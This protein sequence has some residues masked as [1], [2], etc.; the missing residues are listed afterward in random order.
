MYNHTMSWTDRLDEDNA[1]K[2][3]DVLYEAEKTKKI[4]HSI[5]SAIKDLPYDAEDELRN[6]AQKT[7]NGD[8][9]PRNPSPYKR[10]SLT[11]KTRALNKLY[12]GRLWYWGI[13]TLEY[14]KLWNDN[15]GI[16]LNSYRTEYI[17]DFIA[18]GL[19]ESDKPEGDFDLHFWTA[20]ADTPIPTVRKDQES[21]FGL[22]QQAY[23]TGPMRQGTR[24]SFSLPNRPMQPGRPSPQ[25]GLW[26]NIRPG[27][28]DGGM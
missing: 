26:R 16:S 28:H 3:L 24:L 20:I 11:F 2:R 23:K 27:Q 13:Y 17:Y 8:W 14:G 22:L 19:F 6:L 21:F 10:D 18:E 25:G 9:N 7:W 15:D 12:K 4:E 5:K 1:R